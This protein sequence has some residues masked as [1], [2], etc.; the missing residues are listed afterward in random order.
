VPILKLLGKAEKHILSH[1]LCYNLRTLY[2]K[3]C[4]ALIW[5][6]MSFIIIICVIKANLKKKLLLRPFFLSLALAP[7]RCCIECNGFQSVYQCI[8]MLFTINAKTLILKKVQLTP[9]Y[10]LTMNMLILHN[11]LYK[12]SYQNV[13]VVCLIII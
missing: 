10:L 12:L 1:K 8:I 9:F 11:L 4:R 7:Q 13:L 5:D 3:S 2:N 6:I